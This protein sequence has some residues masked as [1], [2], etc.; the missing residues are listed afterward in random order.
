MHILHLRFQTIDSEASRGLGWLISRGF[1][2][3]RLEICE[4]LTIYT[5]LG[6]FYKYI[7]IPRYLVNYNI[8]KKKKQK[9]NKKN[10]NFP[11]NLT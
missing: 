2:R 8:K 9:Q 3:E 11:V 5:C 1:S 7:E 6:L 4:F 10:F